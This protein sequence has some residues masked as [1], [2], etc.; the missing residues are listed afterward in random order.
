MKEIDTFKWNKIIRKM[1]R[2]LK[3]NLFESYSIF[4]LFV[5]F[6]PFST[7]TGS[8]ALT[9]KHCLCNGSKC[10]KSAL[11]FHLSHYQIER[12]LCSPECLDFIYSSP[13]FIFI[14]QHLIQSPFDSRTFLTCTLLAA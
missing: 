4:F 1:E 13:K 10:D 2:M 12:L 9:K 6:Y 11:Q 8:I 3:I 14:F 5:F 7:K